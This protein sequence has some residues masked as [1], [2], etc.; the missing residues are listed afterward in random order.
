[1]SLPIILC[2]QP[3]VG[4]QANPRSS[5]WRRLITPQFRPAISLSMVSFTRP[6]TGGQLAGSTTVAETVRRLIQLYAAVGE[7]NKAEPLLQQAALSEEPAPPIVNGPFRS[8]HDERG[9]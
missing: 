3:L 7:T 4:G 6:L 5:S 9:H 8:E 1:M 2:L